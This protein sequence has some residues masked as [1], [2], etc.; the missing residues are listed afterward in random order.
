MKPKHLV[1]LLIP[2]LVVLQMAF[3]KPASIPIVNVH[4][5]VESVAEVVKLQEV[6]KSVGIVK[7]VLQAIPVD[8][9]AFKGTNLDLGG[10]EE[11]NADLEKV[12]QA[13]PEEFTYFCSIDP[14]DPLRTDKLEACLSAG[15]KG[16]K[17]YNG[18]SYAH[19]TPVDDAKLNDFYSSIAAKG[20]LLMLPVNTGKYE[21]E[22]KNVLT[23]HPDLTVICSH[24]CLSSQD[25]GRL[26]TLMT[27]FPN[28]Y[29]DTSFGNLDFAQEGFKTI[30]NNHDAFVAFFDEFQDRILFGTDAVLTDYEDKTIEWLTALYSDYLAILQESE[31]ESALSSGVSYTGL[32]LP[33]TIQRK[34]LYQNWMNLN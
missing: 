21:D 5:S 11:N 7:T 32:E 1:L 8:L 15:A 29:V 10:V 6:N 26:T 2:V 19:E 30:T 4:E 12:E 27:E 9:V 16:V 20:A 23:L 28:L 17:L 3:S 25:L 31:F 14:N 34:V 24:Y 22:L 13:Y 33:Y 18:Y